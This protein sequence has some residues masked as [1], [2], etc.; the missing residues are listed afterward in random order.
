MKLEARDVAHHTGLDAHHRSTVEKIFTH[1]A[2]HNIQWHDV[3]SLLR[4][5]ATVVQ[6]ADGRY[7]VTL[8]PETETFDTPRHH[9]MDEQQVVD[10]RRMLRGAGIIPKATEGLDT[11]GSPGR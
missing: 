7:T 5:I 8:G 2:G 9:D 1:P 10:L 4:S 3:L 6:E 11:K